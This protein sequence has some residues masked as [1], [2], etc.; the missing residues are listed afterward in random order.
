[1]TSWITDGSVDNVAKWD[2]GARQWHC[3]KAMN[4]AFCSLL[5][6]KN[7]PIGYCPYTRQTNLLEKSQN[8][9]CHREDLYNKDHG[10]DNIAHGYEYGAAFIA[11]II[12][13]CL[14]SLNENTAEYLLLLIASCICE[15]VAES[16]AEQV[17]LQ[18]HISLK[19]FMKSYQ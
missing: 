16:H 3:L 12:Y 14:N 1:M 10:H 5:T 7:V 6:Y 11:I 18:T 4:E 2:K 8:S 13:R 9:K 17:A 15:A 19:A